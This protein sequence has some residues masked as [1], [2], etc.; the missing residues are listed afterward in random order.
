V[1]KKMEMKGITVQQAFDLFDADGDE[2]LTI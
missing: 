1:V 2:V